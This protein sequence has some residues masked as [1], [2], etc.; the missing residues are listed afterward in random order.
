MS[1][2]RNVSSRL[3]AIPGREAGGAAVELAVVL[4]ILVLIAIGIA[5]YARVFATGITIAS[6][7]KAGAQY[8]AQN[9]ATSGD[10]ADIHNA[11]RQEGQEVA[12]IVV[13]SNRICRCPG[14]EN[15]VDCITGSCGSYGV[16][17]VFVSVT[18]SKSV[19]MLFNYPGLPSTIPVRRTATIRVQ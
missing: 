16:P 17:R 4:P 5:D 1:F 11:A 2:W 13:T 6:A 12:P 10:T 14:S 8:G 3:K 7:A 19:A 9:T 18:A 15:G